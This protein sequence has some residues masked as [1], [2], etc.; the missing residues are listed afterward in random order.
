MRYYKPN[1]DFK[2]IL[3]HI[4]GIF[5]ILD[6]LQKKRNKKSKLHFSLKIKNEFKDF[7][8]VMVT[9]Y[10]LFYGLKS[11]RSSF[12]DAREFTLENN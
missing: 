12:L 5:Q 3:L 9:T 2:T 1:I 8:D 7:R 4:A 11:F 10:D 6:C